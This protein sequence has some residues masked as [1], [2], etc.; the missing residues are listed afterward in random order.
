MLNEFNKYI[1]E[2]KLLTPGERVLL[3]VSGGIDSM[4]MTHIILRSGYVAGIAHCNFSLRADESDKDEKMVQQYAAKNNIPFYTTRFDTKTF[5]KEKGLSVQMAARELRY[6][7]FET[8]RRKYKYDKIAIAHNL[9]DNIETVLINLIR[10]TG[11]TGLTGMKSMNNRIIRPI[12]FATRNDI[13]KYSKR[14]RIAYREDMSNADT[15]YLRNKIR[16]NVIPVLKEMNPSIEITLNDTAERLSGLYEIVSDYIYDL[17]RKITEEKNNFITLNISLLRPYLHNRTI[18]FELF[19][20]FGISNVQLNDLIRVIQGKTGGQLFTGTHRIIKNRKEIIVTHEQDVKYNT[21]EI[22]NIQDFEGAPGIRSAEY[23][24]IK[25]SFEIPSDPNTACL[26]AD[27]ITFPVIIRRWKTGDYFYPLGMR[28][29]KKLSDYFIN[30]KYSIVDKENI[31]IMES[32]GKIVWII[33]DRI[34]NRFRITSSTKKNLLIKSAKEV[35]V[36]M[37]VR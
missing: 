25:G 20:P 36:I 4:V 23:F 9:N 2:H 5:A 34:D 16:H 15:K 37:P 13:I 28:N 24:D 33:G 21:Y 27:K 35:M 6:K 26:D 1:S 30:S 22:N 3:A 29:K 31:L 32:E 14:H 8:I 10:G 7:W 12:L 11:I 17:R 19:R 18:L